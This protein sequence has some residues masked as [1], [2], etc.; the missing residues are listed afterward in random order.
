[1]IIEAL[2]DYYDRCDKKIPLGWSK[3]EIRWI[4]VLNDKGDC[5]NL[6]DTQ[7]SFIDK[8]KTKT[9]SKIFCVPVP[10]RRTRDVKANLLWEK[11]IEYLFS[12]KQRDSKQSDSKQSDSNKKTKSFQ[13]RLK[14]I[15][16]ADGSIEPS[17]QAV[18]T[19]LNNDPLRQLEIINPDAAKELKKKNSGA[20]TFKREGDRQILLERPDIRSLCERVIKD[21]EIRQGRCSFSG[22]VGDLISLHDTVSGRVAFLTFQDKKGYFSYGKEKGFNTSMSWEAMKKYT[23]ALK[24][25]FQS[26]DNR[27]S[28]S[29]NEML[30]FWATQ[31]T[32]SMHEIRGLLDPD[33]DAV[34]VKQVFNSPRSGSS[35][36]A[37]SANYFYLLGAYRHSASMDRF[38]IRTWV[39]LPLEE[40]R[41]NVLD[42]FDALWLDGMTPAVRPS[43]KWILYAM[44]PLREAKDKGNPRLDQFNSE[45]LNA[46]LQGRHFPR[47]L[48]SIITS[49]LR[50]DHEPPA[51]RQ[52]DHKLYYKLTQIRIALL[53]AYLIR[54]ANLP[55]ERR[56]QPML[57]PNNP[58]TAYNLGRLFAVF[59]RIQ[60]L[61]LKSE[62]Q[63]L[64]RSIKD[65]FFASA[66]MTPARI[67][68]VLRRN[69]SY[70][71]QKLRGNRWYKPLNR[72]EEL[73]AEITAHLPVKIPALFSLEEQAQFFIGYHH[74]WYALY[75]AAKEAKESRQPDSA[76]QDTVDDEDGIFTELDDDNTVD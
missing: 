10:K 7:E 51:D 40:V 32:E 67:F 1:M 56:P 21:D 70:Y 12:P 48:L 4:I 57:D 5:V 19:F 25:L 30:L 74:Q 13:D 2:I 16:Q 37:A 27:F 54:N 34:K 60:W 9:R 8:K 43:Y 49:R 29:D 42:Y 28:L 73:M 15:K 45:L 35:P 52:S 22:E 66:A 68:S 47:T 23:A 72:L 63:S 18:L 50:T 14:S 59:E 76:R 33:S 61:A 31:E 3:E 11:D 58:D 62:K 44:S 26:K 36:S 55:S 69:I 17:V 6:K 38:S 64:N 39:K 71:E 65:K 41:R 75:Q 46:A 53:K 20:I 24:Y